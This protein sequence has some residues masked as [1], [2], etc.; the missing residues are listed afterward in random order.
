MSTPGGNDTEAPAAGKRLPP[1]DREIIT[2][3][4]HAALWALEHDDHA[5]WRTPR[6]PATDIVYVLTASPRAR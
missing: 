4:L 6:A 5:G 1:Q 3:R 2:K